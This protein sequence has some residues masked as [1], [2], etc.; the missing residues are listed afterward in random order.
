MNPFFRFVFALVLMAMP[1]AGLPNRAEAGPATPMPS[2]E[3][4]NPTSV[5]YGGWSL[6]SGIYF[7]NPTPNWVT[8]E[9]SVWYNNQAINRHYGIGWQPQEGYIRFPERGMTCDEAGCKL[10]LTGS[11]H[12]NSRVYFLTTAS[13]GSRLGQFTLGSVQATFM[14]GATESR[15]SE[16]YHEG[17]INLVEGP[18]F[19]IKIE[20]VD[21]TSVGGYRNFNVRV[22]DRHLNNFELVG[23]GVDCPDATVPE[24]I[25]RLRPAFYSATIATFYGAVYI[26]D[27]PGATCTVTA[28]VRTRETVVATSYTIKQ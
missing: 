26:P 24:W 1:L 15:L 12:P 27:K 9:A 7:R 17:I 21:T 20:P 18:G 25:T 11:I 6:T 10:I 4:F 14:D 5:I 16:A 8:F 3:W 28:L 2:V 23:F 19:S 22:T 13:S